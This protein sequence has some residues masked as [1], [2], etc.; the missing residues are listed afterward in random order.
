MSHKR[1]VQV[2]YRGNVVD[3]APMIAT[4]L[5][6]LHPEYGGWYFE[7]NNLTK[8]SFQATLIEGLQECTC[9]IKG[10]AHL[11]GEDWYIC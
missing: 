10:C 8:M 5:N 1:L 9:L 2:K 7:I 4:P 11:G 6:M 3:K